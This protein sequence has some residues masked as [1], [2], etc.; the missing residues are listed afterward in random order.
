VEFLGEPLTRLTFRRFGTLNTI[1]AIERHT[2]LNE[3]DSKSLLLIPPLPYHKLKGTSK[4]SIAADSREDLR[5]HPPFAHARICSSVNFP[6]RT[7]A[8]R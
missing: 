5:T 3:V 2:T 7:L 4:Y 8:H 6:Y 1:K